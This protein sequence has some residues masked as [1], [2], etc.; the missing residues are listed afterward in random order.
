M[1]AS[2][3]REHMN[4]CPLCIALFLISLRVAFLVCVSFVYLCFIML[5]ASSVTAALY[6]VCARVADL[7]AQS[8]IRE[9]CH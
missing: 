7:S 4:I 9:H 1:G 2:G 5:H 6:K 8:H 3:L